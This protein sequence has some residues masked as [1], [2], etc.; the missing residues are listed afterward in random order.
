MNELLDSLHA[1]FESA[2]QGHVF[3]HVDRLDT[4]QVAAFAAELEAIDLGLVTRLGRKLKES[5]TAA[6]SPLFSP[7]IVVRLGD[8]GEE[9]ALA[10]GNDLLAAGKVGFVLVAGGQGSRLGFDGPKGA[11]EIGPVTSKSLFEWHAARILAAGTRHGFRPTWYI[12]TSRANDE[13]TRT[14]FEARGNFGFPS[15]DI[16]FFSQDMLPALD[17][18]GRIVLAGPGEV[19]LAPDGHGGTLAALHASGA[20][21]HMER[22]GIEE[23]SYFQVDNPLARPADPLFVGRHRAQGAEMSSKVVPKRDAAEKVGVLGLVDG[24]LGCIEY[25]DLSDELREARTE[26]GDLVFNAG[27]IAAHMISR[28][29]VERLNRGGALDLPWHIARKELATID[30]SGEPTKLAGVKFETFVFD[31]LAQA[32]ACVTLEV[33]RALEFSPVKNAD[34][35]DSPATCQADLSAIG[36]AIAGLNG[37]ASGNGG[38]VEAGPVEIDPRAAETADEFRGRALRLEQTQ[39]GAFCAAPK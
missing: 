7:P 16:Y 10:R 25:S 24:A 27:N 36:R 23:L 8:A 19:F 38:P 34:G 33:D 39:G 29:F 30:A 28:G 11:F 2:G 22:R 13:E 15:E 26:G 14:F 20:L 32:K 17:A 1:R 35:S 6:R 21:E 18:E 12:M 31:A 3:A 9:Q 37:G 4:D 5:T